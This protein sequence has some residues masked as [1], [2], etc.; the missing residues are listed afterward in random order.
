MPYIVTGRDTL[1]VHVALRAAIRVAR[2]LLALELRGAY[3]RPQKVGQ[4]PW[5]IRYTG[6]Q[7]EWHT[8]R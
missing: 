1:L 5:Q 3:T 4:V 6:N 8:L 2:V 7:L